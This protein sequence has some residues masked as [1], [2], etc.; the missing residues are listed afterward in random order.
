MSKKTL[1][2]LGSLALALFAVA[3]VAAM[4][5]S[6]SPIGAGAL[7]PILNGAVDQAQPTI[8]EWISTGV[9][10]GLSVFLIWLGR[11]VGIRLI[12]KLNRDAIRTA[13]KNFSNSVID[14]LQ[15]RFLKAGVGATPDLSDLVER[16]LA[17]VAGGSKDA[18]KENKVEAARLR[19]QVEG[20]LREKGTDLLAK[21]LAKFPGLQAPPLG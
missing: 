17:Y 6:F 5:L 19:K 12:E 1:L 2:T 13:S 8:T 9:D 14:E 15:G 11:K 21:E 4:A 7:A 20:A 10:T 3:P 18:I 16:G